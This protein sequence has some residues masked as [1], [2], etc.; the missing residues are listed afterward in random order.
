M[1]FIK[2]KVMELALKGKKLLNKNS[3]PFKSPFFVP[4]DISQFYLLLRFKGL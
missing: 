2:T 4:Q 1:K 3:W